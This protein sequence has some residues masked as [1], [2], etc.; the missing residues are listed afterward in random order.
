[1]YPRHESSHAP[2]NRMPGGQMIRRGRNEVSEYHLNEIS[3]A[4]RLLDSDNTGKIDYQE[5][6]VALRALGFQ[7]HK[8][9]V[10]QLMTKHDPKNTG[11][12]DFEAFKSI[13]T[14]L[15]CRVLLSYC[16]D[17][18]NIRKGSHG[19]NKYVI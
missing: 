6:K 10:L 3:A 5:L 12:I 2:L 7:V 14:L 13:S 4:F 8:K 19:G 11:Y 18:K 16:S 17:Q 15:L 9:E 1:M